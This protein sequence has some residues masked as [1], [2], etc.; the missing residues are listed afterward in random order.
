MTKAIG[1]IPLHHG[2]PYL[3]WTIRSFIDAVDQCVII[4]CPNS[5]HGHTASEPCPDRRDDLYAAAI[6]GASSKLL[7]V[8]GYEFHTEGDH[9]DKV[10]ELVPDADIVLAAD[11]DEVFAEGAAAE[12]IRLAREGTV[13]NYRLPFIHYWRSFYRAILHDPAY[14]IRVMNTRYPDGEA[15]LTTRPVNHFGYAIPIYLCAYKWGNVH[16]HRNQLRTDINWLQER[17]IA[18]ASEDCH[19]VGSQYWTVEDV[20]PLD[21]M[22]SF[23]QEHPFFHMEVIP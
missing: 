22:P 16:S 8:E 15:Y 18:N 21:Y 14:P 2:L 1:F 10:Y 17:Y 13:R 20:R 19:P 3:E 11:F 4:Y 7:W 6:R 5:S 9:R 12:A 23:M